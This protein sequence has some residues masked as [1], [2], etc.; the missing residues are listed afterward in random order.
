M[1]SQQI[2]KLTNPIYNM[3]KNQKIQIK[4]AYQVGLGLGKGHEEAL[5]GEEVYFMS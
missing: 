2:G 3:E 5:W 4:G 1:V